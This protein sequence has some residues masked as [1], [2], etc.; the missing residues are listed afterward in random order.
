M[1]SVPEHSFDPGSEAVAWV[2]LVDRR[3][4]PSRL[5]AW[6]P[7]SVVFG[8]LNIVQ[9]GCSGSGFSMARK[10]TPCNVRPGFDSTSMKASFSDLQLLELEG[11]IARKLR[12]HIFNSW[13]LKEASHKSSVFIHHGCHLNVRICTKPCVF[14]AKRSFG[15]GEK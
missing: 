5:S 4:W 14:S 13:N 7:L 1:Q 6:P 3:W 12:F 15:C 8:L 2:S 10:G 9:S 11:S